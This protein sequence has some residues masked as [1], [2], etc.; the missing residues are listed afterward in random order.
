M[1]T[2][3]FLTITVAVFASVLTQ[4]FD[5]NEILDDMKGQ[6]QKEIFKAFHDLHN[7]E[8][9]LNSEEAIK[10]YRIFKANSKWIEEENKKLG[11]KVYGITEFFDMTHEEFIERQLV[12][13][14]IMESHLKERLAERSL[15]FLH[16]NH[17]DHHNHD[18]H[19][20][21]DHDE[22]HD[23]KHP[24]IPPVREEDQGHDITTSFVFNCMSS[25]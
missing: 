15:R 18:H 7:K 6:P 8:Y 14:E 9:N 12:K 21:D 17:H 23:I 4:Q 19:H 22:N 24:D 20:H 5:V 1:N 25:N 11:K 10:R 2:F 16:E 13:P 3:I